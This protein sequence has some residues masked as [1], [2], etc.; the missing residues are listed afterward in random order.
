[1]PR[2]TKQNEAMRAATKTAVLQSAITLFAQNGYA[3]TSTRAIAKHAGISVGLMYHYFDSKETLLRAVFD[4]SMKRISDSFTK[5]LVKG[6]P[7]QR[8]GLIL[9]SLFT[10]LVEDRDFWALFYMLRTQPAIAQ[11][12]DRELRL[13]TRMLRDLFEAELFKM[14]RPNAELDAYLLYS[15]IE[16]TIQQFLLDP[17]NYPLEAVVN[18]IIRQYTT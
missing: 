5:K 13:W 11:L 17:A 8:L 2:S 1:M 18:E 14:G 6:H 12:L 4:H 16:G 9:H 10:L 7:N 15:L 3:H